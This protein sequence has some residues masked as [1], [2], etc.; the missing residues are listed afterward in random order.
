[1]CSTSCNFCVSIPSVAWTHLQ[2]LKYVGQIRAKSI[3]G[4]NTSIHSKCLFH[5]LSILSVLSPIL[6]ALKPCHISRQR[7]LATEASDSDS[8]PC[9]LVTRTWFFPLRSNYQ[10]LILSFVSQLPEP[11]SS[12][13]VLITRVWFFLLLPLPDPDS[14][15][16][17]LVTRTWFFLL[18]PSY[19][20]LILPLVS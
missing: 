12:P 15:P 5:F 18:C 20:N 17:V 2:D 3:Y 16:C 11:D 7:I 13:C 1:M 19:Q 8:S 6:F 9:V 10:S 14:S 4:G